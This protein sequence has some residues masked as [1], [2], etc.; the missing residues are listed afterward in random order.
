[1]NCTARYG[2]GVADR[3]TFLTNHGRVLLTLAQDPDARLRDI[4][5]QVGITER[6]AQMIVSDLETEGYLTKQ[7]VGRR[8]HYVLDKR[9]RFRH[10]HEAGHQVG[11]LLSLFAER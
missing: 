11:E 1:V 2:T 10:P 8:N 9:K 6:A 4:A 5:T 7:R 3:W